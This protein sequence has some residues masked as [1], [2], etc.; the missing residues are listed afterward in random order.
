MASSVVP[1]TLV[2]YCTS[3]LGRLGARTAAMD[4]HGPAGGSPGPRLVSGE[5]LLTGR[6]LAVC[7][8]GLSLTRTPVL[9]DEGPASQVQGFNALLQILATRG[10]EFQRKLGRGGT[11]VIS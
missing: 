1:C 2:C 4:S 8:L 5:T 6:W 11:E 9:G 3:P 10:L 7:A